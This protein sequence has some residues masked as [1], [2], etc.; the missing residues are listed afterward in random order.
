MTEHMNGDHVITKEGG[1]SEQ[2]NSFSISNAAI[3]VF[4]LIFFGRAASIYSNGD[5][6]IPLVF[7]K[8]DP[9]H[10][11]DFC[12]LVIL[13]LIIIA[14]DLDHL[15][16]GPIYKAPGDTVIPVNR[17]SIQRV[18]SCDTQIYHLRM[19]SVSLPVANG[20]SLLDSSSL[21]KQM[22]TTGRLRASPHEM[23]PSS[24]RALYSRITRKSS[25]ASEESEMESAKHLSELDEKKLKLVGHKILRRWMLQSVSLAFHGWF[26]NADHR[27]RMRIMSKKIMGR[28]LKMAC[29]GAFHAWDENAALTMRLRRLESKIVSIC[30][31]NSLRGHFI[32]WTILIREM[33]NQE[34][35][36]QRLQQR[37]SSQLR[38]SAFRFWTTYTKRRAWF[39]RAEK[40][41]AKRWAFMQVRYHS[42]AGSQALSDSLP[43]IH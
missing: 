7:E 1:K 37:G 19:R 22:I 8:A 11:F 29:W 23:A 9:S 26:A 36:A 42:P 41:V 39:G 14:N 2:S 18:S 31:R 28:W 16:H 25:S 15:V 34:R 38:I 35:G 10:F 32:H 27:R 17:N 12:F 43:L 13:L 6:A 40:A 20:G 21:A 33:E 4:L 5:D 3:V 24:P 30:S